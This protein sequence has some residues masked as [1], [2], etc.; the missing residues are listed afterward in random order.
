MGARGGDAPGGNRGNRRRGGGSTRVVTVFKTSDGVYKPRTTNGRGGGG[1]PRGRGVSR[2]RG[3]GQGRGGGRGRGGRG[4]GRGRGR[5]GDRDYKGPSFVPEGKNFD[6]L[7]DAEK[8]DV[9]RQRNEWKAAQLD[10]DLIS[11]MAKTGKPETANAMLDD[12][13]ENYKKQGGKHKT[14]QPQD[15]EPQQVAEAM[16]Q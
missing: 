12:D 3:N 5:N 10:K 4:R 1:G 8:D 16:E 11:Y 15:S 9:F 6:Q 14:E 13:L 7:T 2:G